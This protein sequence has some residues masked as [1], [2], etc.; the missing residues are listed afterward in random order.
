MCMRRFVISQQFEH[1]S[2]RVSVLQV[3]SASG[4]PITYSNDVIFASFNDAKDRE[5][6]VYYSLEQALHSYSK[7]KL[8]PPVFEVELSDTAVLQPS[9]TGLMFTSPSSISK[10]ISAT[11]AGINYVLSEVCQQKSEYIKG[12]SSLELKVTTEHDGMVRLRTSELNTLLLSLEGKLSYAELVDI[13]KATKKFLDAPTVDNRKEYQA[14]AKT[15]QGASSL[16]L[17]AI[18]L[19]MIALAFAVMTAT[20]FVSA[21]LS[22]AL[23]GCG[24]FALGRYT[25]G[26]SKAMSKLALA[27]PEQ[28]F[29]SKSLS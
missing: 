18:G 21:P 6:C 12:V 11:H 23:A 5:M 25:T 20:A 14:I 10:F 27:V 15:K 24:I 2:P 9:F 16:A 4:K 22:I 7:D 1:S 28:A 19:C 17:Q 13:L 3:K 8:V 26:L 29:T